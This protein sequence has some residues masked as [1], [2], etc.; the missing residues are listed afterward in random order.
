MT[1]IE[2]VDEWLP[3]PD[4]AHL[5]GV[6]V[7]KTRQLV[8]DRRV[9][10]L[11]VGARNIFCVPGKFLVPAHLENPAN[12]LPIPANEADG[13]VRPAPMVLLSS[14][15]GTLSVLGDVG[16]TDAEVIDWLFSPD[17]EIGEAP[18][19]A[20]RNGRKSVVR[21]VAQALA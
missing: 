10:G 9:V 14:L 2:L 8:Q 21:R 6:E 12:V 15:K 7:S 18:I 20:L 19:D 1:G 11:K 16:M 4:L 13:D 3:L 5:L 17:E